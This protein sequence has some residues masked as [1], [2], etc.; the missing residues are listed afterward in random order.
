[1]DEY[2]TLGRRFIESFG[3]A[4]WTFN[5]AAENFDRTPTTLIIALELV[6]IVL[7]IFAV[8]YVKRFKP[9]I[10]KR[11]GILMV[12]IGSFEMFT[13][14]MWNNFKLG[15]WAYMYRDVSWIL[16]LAWSALILTIIVLVDHYKKHWRPEWRFLGI[17][18]IL[19]MVVLPLDSLLI[20]VGVRSYTPE[21]EAVIWGRMPVFGVPWNILYYI[22]VFCGLI[23]GFYRYWELV[24]EQTPVLPF[25]HRLWFRDFI[26]A[27]VA[28]FMFEVMVEPMVENVGFP[29][30]SYIYRDISFL[31]T[32][33]W[34]A[35]IGLSLKIVDTLFIHYSVFKRF[36]LYVTL[37]TCVAAPLEAFMMEHGFR[38]YSP[39]TAANFSG[40]RLPVLNIPVEV[41]FGFY[42]YFSLV[43]CFIR[44]WEVILDQRRLTHV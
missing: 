10:L 33:S 39:T 21:V 8:L 24:L 22:P 19:T 2:K 5:F 43:V 35:I 14:S 23:L 4:S 41:I 15:V 12:A 16:M 28:V 29:S 40:L 26:I 32:L 3:P 37:L 34:V 13:M 42:L 18:G 17:L 20:K 9:D 36:F 7:S 1:M 31:L 6:T 44:Y 38:V 30:W 25:R 11:L 27:I